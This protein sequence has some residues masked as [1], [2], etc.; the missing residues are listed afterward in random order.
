MLYSVAT[1]AQS[2]F[3][4]CFYYVSKL[5]GNKRVFPRTEWETSINT[6]EGGKGGS[7]SFLAVRR[8]VHGEAFNGSVVSEL[9][10]SSPVVEGG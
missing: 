2:I 4:F 9:L 7:C 6:T 5:R 10:D 3:F 1:L 8:L